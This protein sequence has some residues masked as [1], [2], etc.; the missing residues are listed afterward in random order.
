MTHIEH[1]FIEFAYTTSSI[2]KYVGFLFDVQ[3]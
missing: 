1:T 2:L 3:R